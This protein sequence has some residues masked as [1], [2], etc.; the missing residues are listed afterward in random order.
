MSQ[1]A[2]DDD[3][4]DLPPSAKYVLD[5]VERAGPIRRQELLEETSLAE[6]TLDR[7]LTTL[8]NEGFIL[9]TRKSTDLRQTTIKLIAE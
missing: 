7:A 6:P 8:Q 5:V 9:R 1:N 4:D 3:V 2:I